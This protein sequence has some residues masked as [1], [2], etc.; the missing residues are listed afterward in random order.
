VA[1]NQF[2]VSVISSSFHIEKKIGGAPRLRAGC[3]TELLR[4]SAKRKFPEGVA[5]FA[6]A[7]AGTASLTLIVVYR[8]YV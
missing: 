3:A 5:P 8:Y 4:H 2:L 6:P 7:G 1:G